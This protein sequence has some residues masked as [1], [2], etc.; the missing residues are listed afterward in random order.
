M[1][2]TAERTEAVVRRPSDESFTG[3]R[4]MLRLVLRRNRVRLAV[5]FVVLVGLFAYV[6]AYYADILAT[7]AALDD[8]AALSNTPGI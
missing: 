1:T 3:T 7:Q 5:W 8:F 2:A 6:A 4:T